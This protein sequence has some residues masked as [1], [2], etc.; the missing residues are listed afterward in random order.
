MKRFFGLILFINFLFS[1]YSA[2]NIIY[3]QNYLI[4]SIKSIEIKTNS[5]NVK[6]IKYY[7]EDILVEIDSNMIKNCPNIKNE[8]FCLKINSSQKKTILGFKCQINIYVPSEMNFESLRINTSSG[9]IQTEKINAEIFEIHSLSGN[10]SCETGN[11]IDFTAGSVSGS[12]KL[13]GIFAE[14][15]DIE[16]K[17]GNISL[18]LL[19]IPVAKSFVSATSGS[20]KIFV[21]KNADFNLNIRT[22]SGSFWDDLSG[23]KGNFCD[24]NKQYGV[25]GTVIDLKTSSG[26]VKL[27]GY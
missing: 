12:L 22:E 13:N 6:I 20:I 4:D 24:F 15:F 8:D 19:Q 25:G 18:D 16:S 11:F 23:Y 27:M 17:T 1:L 9:I 3:N 14:Y 21:P 26:S 10:I 2:E 7:G 5:E